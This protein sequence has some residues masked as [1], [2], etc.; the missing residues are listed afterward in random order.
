M[1]FVLVPFIVLSLI[2]L[3]LMLGFMGP[4]ITDIFYDFKTTIG[5]QKGGSELTDMAVKNNDPIVCTKIAP[6]Y[7]SN[8]NGFPGLTYRDNVNCLVKVAD[9]HRNL[10]ACVLIADYQFPEQNDAL[11]CINRNSQSPENDYKICN[12]FEASAQR[13]SCYGVFVNKSNNPSLCLNINDTF[14]HDSCLLVYTSNLENVDPKT[15]ELFV[16]TPKALGSEKSDLQYKCYT[17][18]AIETGDISWCHKTSEKDGNWC[19]NKVAEVKT[20]YRTCLSIED[21]TD[22]FWGRDECLIEIT[23]RTKTNEACNFVSEENV[24]RCLIY[25][26]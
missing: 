1:I 23:R 8:I 26:Q 6:T 13:G 3:G 2:F 17:R 5:L 15:C 19:I 25:V 24:D 16:G 4:K 12:E 18:V 14:E 21:T 10:N 22:P 9:A 7:H 11:T 20:D